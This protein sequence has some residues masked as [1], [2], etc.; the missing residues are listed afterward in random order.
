MTGRGR[1]S[2]RSYALF[3]D[4]HLKRLVKIAHEGQEGLFNRNPRLAVYRDRLLLVALCQGGAQ[5]YVDCNT[6]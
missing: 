4:E 3:T 6:V 5:H 2:D 1:G